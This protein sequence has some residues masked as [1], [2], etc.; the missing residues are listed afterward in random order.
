MQALRG[1]AAGARGIAVHALLPLVG[2]FGAALGQ[3]L[4]PAFDQR[5]FTRQ[6]QQL[7]DVG[8][9]DLGGGHRPHRTIAAAGA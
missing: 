6:L 2:G 9:V 4:G 8:G 3:A 7:F 1:L 5:L